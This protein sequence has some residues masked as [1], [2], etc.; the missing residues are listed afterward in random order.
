MNAQDLRLLQLAS[1]LTQMA[2]L[3]RD[4]GA[5]LVLPLPPPAEGATQFAPE[6]LVTE[7]TQRGITTELRGDALYIRWDV[8]PVA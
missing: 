5:Y 6:W 3:A 7:L 8:S 4:A 1:I 2:G